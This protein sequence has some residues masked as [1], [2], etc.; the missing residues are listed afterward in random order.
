M[1][2][3]EIQALRAVS[4]AARPFAV[5]A[6]PAGCRCDSCVLRRILAVALDALDECPR[7]SRLSKA[8]QLARE[9]PRYGDS[10]VPPPAVEGGAYR[11]RGK[12]RKARS[13]KVRR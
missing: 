2:L 1:R 11:D 8:A 13:T 7:G 10:P 6:G 3:T 5:S 4:E 12:G 9:P